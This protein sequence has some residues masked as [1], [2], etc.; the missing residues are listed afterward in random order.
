MSTRNL[1]V[2]FKSAL[3]KI[4]QFFTEDTYTLNLNQKTETFFFFE[5]NLKIQLVIISYYSEKLMKMFKKTLLGLKFN[6]KEKQMTY[7]ERLQLN[8]GQWRV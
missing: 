6:L 4:F 2:L 3:M 1:F 7:Q 5:V 8:R